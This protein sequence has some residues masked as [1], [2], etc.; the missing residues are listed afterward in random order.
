MDLVKATAKGD[1]AH[2]SMGFGAAYIRG[3][4]LS[5][6]KIYLPYRPFHTAGFTTLRNSVPSIKNV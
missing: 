5:F 1:E 3:L 2:L 4:T 6:A